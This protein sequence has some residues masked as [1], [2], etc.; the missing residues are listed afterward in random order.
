MQEYS[1]SSLIFYVI[2]RCLILMHKGH[3]ILLWV[4]MKEVSL[5]LVPS[6]D[7]LLVKAHV[8]FPLFAKSGY[9]PPGFFS[10]LF[11]KLFNEYKKERE[12]KNPGGTDQNSKN[13]L[14]EKPPGIL[15]RAQVVF[16]GLDPFKGT[17]DESEGRFDD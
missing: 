11:W 14:G 9:I 7:Q 4:R 16:K 13:N 10:F 3:F 15:R 12:K 8:L 1:V 5:T 17:R 2:I 6:L